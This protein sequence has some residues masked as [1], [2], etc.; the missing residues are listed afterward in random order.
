[1]ADPP[2]KSIPNSCH[3]VKRQTDWNWDD[4]FEGN[5]KHEVNSQNHSSNP[6]RLKIHNA[7]LSPLEDVIQLVQ[8]PKP[9]KVA[10]KRSR[11]IQHVQISNSASSK[12][13]E[14]IHRRN[15]LLP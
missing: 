2:D 9:V 8:L 1:M 6:F 5:Y 11:S 12:Q 3:K 7:K 13:S 14:S 4:T 15:L 10:K